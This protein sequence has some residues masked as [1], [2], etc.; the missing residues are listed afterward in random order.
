MSITLPYETREWAQFQIYVADTFRSPLVKLPMFRVG[1]NGYDLLSFSRKTLPDIGRASFRLRY[2]IIDGRTYRTVDSNGDAKDGAPSLLGKEVIIVEVQADGT[3]VVRWWGE[4]LYEEEQAWPGSAEPAGAKIYH[5]VDGLYR[6][7]RWTLDRHLW[8][9]NGAGSSSN[10]SRGHPG[11]N[12]NPNGDPFT[13]QQ[14]VGNK[15][16]T[17]ITQ[18][19]RGYR[20]HTAPS[21][22][23]GTWTD[24]EALRHAFLS[25]TQPIVTKA[26]DPNEGANVTTFLDMNG[27]TG[28][29]AGANQWMIDEGESLWSFMTRVLD[30]R[31]G[32]GLCALTFASSKSGDTLADWL[33]PRITV[34]TQFADDVTWTPPTAGGSVTIQGATNQGTTQ[35]IDLIGDHRLVDGSF[36]VAAESATQYTG[37]E[38]VG[39]RLQVVCT[40]STEGPGLEQ[41]WLAA[42]ATAYEAEAT[43]AGNAEDVKYGHVYRSLR[44]SDSYSFN[45]R[46]YTTAGAYTNSTLDLSV[47]A[48]GDGVAAGTVRVDIPAQ[49]N[50]LLLLEIEDTV[51]IGFGWDYTINPR[52]RYSGSEY[53]DA[54]AMPI[55]VY[56]RTST[57]NDDKSLER[58]E[59]AC[60]TY[61]LS[62]TRGAGGRE[63]LLTSSQDGRPLQ[64]LLDKDN[65][66][67]TVSLKLTNRLRLFSGTRDGEVKRIHAPEHRLIL[68]HNGAILR[69][70]SG[71]VVEGRGAYPAA[72]P[73]NPK[74][75][76]GNALVDGSSNPINFYTIRDDRDALAYLHEMAKQ[77]YLTERK[78]A[79]W[80]IADFGI[81]SFEDE[82]GNSINYPQLGY[83]VTTMSYS[84]RTETL[85]TPITSIEYDHQAG[86]TSYITSWSDRDW[87]MRI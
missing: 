83:L 11:Y 28:I 44:I 46:N 43:A 59:D 12:I 19:A 61:G 13:T 86:I 87:G 18:D 16:S 54:P 21:G 30:R 37:I 25:S 15:E 77:W 63:M 6:T 35:T 74:D 49:A 51:P 9:I 60:S 73:I 62:V 23:A 7:R 39:E 57:S 36:Q 1:G 79:A 3:E 66:F 84:G 76:N 34:Y 80:R 65:L 22:S 64:T 78:T 69:L 26:G 53:W 17:N 4:V 85:N 67:F 32:A 48:D 70:Q 55:Q 47:D 41:G 50:S 81:G 33:N 56:E 2:G 29:F 82:D 14:I 10:E 42:E 38:T 24:Q 58:Y 68:A 71:T 20:A 5:C 75:A 72:S 8:Y 40:L 52:A 45:A 31:K 27:N